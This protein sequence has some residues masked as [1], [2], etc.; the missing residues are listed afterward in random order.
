MKPITDTANLNQNQINCLK[1]GIDQL[2]NQLKSQ[3]DND[4]K[5]I[6]QKLSEM[7]KNGE[8]LKEMTKYA[9]QYKKQQR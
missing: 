5:P 1:T 7:F 9:T 4:N 3:S 2:L 8:L 6:D